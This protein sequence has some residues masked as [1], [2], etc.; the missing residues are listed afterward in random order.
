MKGIWSF[1]DVTWRGYGDDALTSAYLILRIVSY[2]KVGKSAHHV[3]HWKKK[4]TEIFSVSEIN[5]CMWRRLRVSM[6]Y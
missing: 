2:R 6:S 5:G 3:I 1:K 4:K